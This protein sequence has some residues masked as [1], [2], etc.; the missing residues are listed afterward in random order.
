M[1]YTSSINDNGREIVAC[2]STN[3][4]DVTGSIE[5]TLPICVKTE[6]NGSVLGSFAL[7]AT[8]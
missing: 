3:S 1:F 8:H 7:K 5:E 6:Y 2:G 4:P